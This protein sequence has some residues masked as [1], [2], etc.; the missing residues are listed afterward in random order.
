MA[1][2]AV[3]Q[4]E[5]RRNFRRNR[6]FRDRQQPLEMYDDIDLL[7][8]FRMPRHV[9]LEVID[10][11]RDDIEHPTRR[12]HAI[13]PSI[14][15][16]CALRYFATG[17]FQYVSGDLLG[18]SQPSVSRIIIRV[19]NAIVRRG[20]RLISFPDADAELQRIKE[21]FYGPRRQ[22]PNVVG[23]VDG[24]LIPIKRPSQNEVA[25]VSRRNTHD[26]NVQGVCSHDMKFTNL[27]ARW[28]GATHDA[29]I[30]N[31]CNLN[32]RFRE[33]DFGHEA[34][35]LG[36]SAYPLRPWLLTPVLQPQN[37]AEERYNRHHR[38]MR[39]KIECTFGR[40]KMRWLCLHRMGKNQV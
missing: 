10:M 39:Q 35:L 23:C 4:A 16:L 3:I 21:G 40:W 26:I 37:E 15:V 30:W 22:I 2:A 36:D 29:F 5:A 18:I 27:V 38:R 7:K 25:Y 17:N 19:A 6:V 13:P 11:I 32:R 9:I 12:N 8:R 28:P 33:G 20:Q 1:V 14:Q 24:S 34:F 31:T